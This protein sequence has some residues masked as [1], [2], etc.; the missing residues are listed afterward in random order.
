ALEQIGERQLDNSLYELSWQP[1]P[2]DAARADAE[3]AQNVPHDWLVFADQGGIASELATR[4]HAKGH[5][6][7]LVRPGRFTAEVGAPHIDPTSISDY[8]RLLAEL[9]KAGRDI[10]G[11]V[12][13]WSLDIAPW[14]GISA[15]DLAEAPNQG[16]VSVMLLAQAL[17][18]ENPVPRLWIVT[19]GAQQA[20]PLDL[21]LSP[22][23]APVWGLRNALAIEHPELHCVCV[24][25]DPKTNVAD[26]DS[27]AAEV[28]GPAVEPQAAFRG[29]QRRVARLARLRHPR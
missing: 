7:T 11:I 20:D 18:D 4:L 22:A 19:R 10:R 24:D 17:V 9:R 26:L 8:R 29:G 28:T 14:D 5:R 23:Q 1:A 15:T 16:A 21:K 25:L 3:E 13:A 2:L 6:C 12:H 27:L